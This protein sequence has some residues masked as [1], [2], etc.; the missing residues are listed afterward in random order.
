[1]YKI[2][3]SMLAEFSY[4]IEKHFGITSIL[5]SILFM[6]GCC[7][8]VGV[9]IMKTAEIISC[10]KSTK[11]AKKSGSKSGGKNGITDSD[12]AASVVSADNTGN[13]E[14]GKCKNGLSMFPVYVGFTVVCSYMM[15]RLIALSYT[16]DSKLQRVMSNFHYV[17]SF[18]ANR[19]LFLNALSLP[20][21]T[22]NNNG[23]FQI[24]MYLNN[25][26]WQNV[27]DNA[28]G[29]QW[30]FG[31]VYQGA[32]MLIPI[33]LIIVL[34]VILLLKGKKLH[35]ILVL[36]CAGLCAFGNFGAVIFMATML[37]LGELL[38]IIVDSSLA[39]NKDLF[40]KRKQDLA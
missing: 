37:I 3:K 31:V 9:V 30:Y 32:A 16:W 35:G 17:L 26:Q 12:E 39:K 29:S 10:C 14:C 2:L 40:D 22:T 24:A 7:A 21:N 38:S 11:K 4:F 36:V 27:Y 19:K 25:N 23:L 13:N 28:G 15:N 20:D 8:I 33:A 18:K 6:A 5:W 34:G 1:M